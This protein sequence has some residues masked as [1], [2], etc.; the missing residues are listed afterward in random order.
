VRIVY[1]DGTGNAAAIAD[2]SGLFTL[3]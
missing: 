1:V 3:L 2:S